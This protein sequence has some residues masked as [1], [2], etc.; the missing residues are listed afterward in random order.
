MEHT[1]AI[2]VSIAASIFTGLLLFFV[3]RYFKNM[4]KRAERTECR[5]EQKD[6]L[7]LRSLKAIGELTVANAIAVKT[8][9]SNGEL[10]KAQKDFEA[11]DKELDSFL[12]RSSV[13]S[14]KK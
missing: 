6:V 12:I 9:H 13:A 5:S 11:V 1:I 14:T 2:V 10:D 8:G 3:Q 7:I 4:E